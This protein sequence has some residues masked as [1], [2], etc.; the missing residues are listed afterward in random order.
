M[1]E[2]KFQPTPT[3]T[4][5]RVN[6]GLESGTLLPQLKAKPF[7][8]TSLPATAQP[9]AE[10]LMIEL[11][12]C[13]GLLG[14][15]NWVD[16]LKIL[17]A[18]A[19]RLPGIDSGGIYLH[20]E[21]NHALRLIAHQG[22]SENFTQNA[23]FRDADPSDGR[24]DNS[25]SR[26]SPHIALAMA[27]E[28]F[29]SVV[30]VPLRDQTRV[31]AILSVFSRSH[32]QI[33]ENSRAT[34]ESLAARAEVAI[35]QAL[36]RSARL[37]SMHE[38]L[39][40][41]EGAGLG[42]WVANL[43]TGFFHASARAME[44]HGI[45]ADTP[46]TMDLAMAAVHPEDQP[47]IAA[48]L[49]QVI[50]HGGSF[51]CE[52]RTAVEADGRR[53]LASQAYF[54]ENEK[55][56]YGVVRNIT[57]RKRAEMA[58]RE[59]HDQLE[60][61]VAERTKQLE[62]AN[63]A[64]REESRRLEMALTASQ[65]GTW[66]LTIGCNTSEWDKRSRLLFGFEEDASVS[67]EDALSRLHPSHKD[68]Y[69]DKLQQVTLPGGGDFWSHEFRILHPTLGERWIAGIGSIER[70][71]SGHALRMSGINL[72]ITGRKQNEETMRG[73][74]QTL[75]RRVA[76]R[77]AEL[78]QS[79]ARFRQLVDASL[80]GIVISRNGIIIDGNPQIASMLG[81]NLSDII[82]HPVLDFI[83]PE[84]RA[85][86][87]S[88]IAGGVET[89]YEITGLRLD[90]TTLPMEVHGRMMTWHGEKT[91]VTAVRD[92]TA[93]KQAEARLVAQKTELDH[94]LRLALISEVSAGII[95][96][97]GQPLSAIG[98]NL[99]AA[100]ARLNSGEENSCDCRKFFDDTAILVARMRDSVIH[101]KALADPE[102][103]NRV[104]V[105]LNDLV[106]E[107]LLLAQIEASGQRFSL[108][109]EMAP[110]LPPLLADKVQ[111][112]QVVINLVRNAFDASADCP[113]ERCTVIVS[114][115][116][117]A[118][119]KIELSVRD[120]GTGIAPA[121]MDHLY[122]PFFTTKAEGFGI[123][124]RLSRTIVQAHGGSIEGFNNSDGNGA[125]FRVVLPPGHA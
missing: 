21:E 1:K 56:L 88:H 40:A 90:G 50:A 33:G 99:A 8:T 75:E 9:P 67:Y 73:W 60:L 118:N 91:R 17:L 122:A 10:H 103:P 28:G 44:L 76:L 64:L 106:S 119:G 89:H 97:I 109:T 35:S 26:I 121:V 107:A 93:Q 18:A 125:T 41:V 100:T 108:M 3:A 68:A 112:S 14:S 23:A 30:E 69:L 16:S 102:Q 101:L 32:P 48:A 15:Q 20:E 58:L 63:A 124:L 111:L 6:T 55:Q 86:V 59:T 34:L 11:D 45:A 47:V 12:L 57:R 2:E 24:A 66:A 85:I 65:A 38:S 54:F 61:R 62:N 39:L 36:A 77:T 105:R 72:D 19:M 115:R 80:E 79:E 96:Q 120:S 70:D 114:T 5:L 7:A 98:A 110:D 53:W 49:E 25:I 43:S 13:I 37:T 4:S 117:M 51:S 81:C 83:A 113:P 123:G 104:P 42:T 84:S 94:A 27:S 22:L 74:N 82:G 92:L 31:I 116:T 95:H 78:K 46:M 52:Y 29:A 87:T 71:E